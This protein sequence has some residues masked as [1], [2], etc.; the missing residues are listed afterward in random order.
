M[1]FQS[2]E[3]Q[4]SQSAHQNM[5]PNDQEEPNP[6]PPRSAND[7]DRL[8][9]SLMG[10]TQQLAAMQVTALNQQAN[11]QIVVQ[12]TSDTIQSIPIFDGSPHAKVDQFIREVE[13]IAIIS[14]W[15]QALTML[16]ATTRL[17]GSALHTGTKCMVAPFTI[18]KRTRPTFTNALNALC[19]CT[20]FQVSR[21]T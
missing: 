7:T 12:S 10:L 21:E 17:A 4:S 9:Q 14:N 1:Y 13:R 6:P 5:V 2:N 11:P 15:S 8:I 18:G 16:N 19:Q 20:S 3:A